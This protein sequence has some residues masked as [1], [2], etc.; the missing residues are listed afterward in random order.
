MNLL[1]SMGLFSAV[2]TG[3]HWNAHKCS[4]LLAKDC[5]NEKK[6]ENNTKE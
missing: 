4:I 5:K 6:D 3:Y 2:F 1:S